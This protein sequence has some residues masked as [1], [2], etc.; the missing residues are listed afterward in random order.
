MRGKNIE[1]IMK[2]LLILLIFIPFASCSK[3]DKDCRCQ[4]SVQMVTPEGN[5][6]GYTI[7]GVPSDCDGG[8]D[9]DALNLPDDHFVGNLTNCR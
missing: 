9:K 1:T 8:Y 3:E 5:I 6:Q 4:L 2:K 7:T